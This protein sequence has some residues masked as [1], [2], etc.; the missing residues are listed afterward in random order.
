MIVWVVADA[1]VKGSETGSSFRQALFFKEIGFNLHD[2]MIWNK[3][4]SFIYDITRYYA[5]FEYMF[6]LSKG[7]PKAVNLIKDKPN[8]T[9]GKAVCY[10]KRQVDGT[11]SITHGHTHNK[12]VGEYGIRYNVWDIYPVQSNLERTGHPAQFPEQLARDHIITWSD[13]GDVV[14]DPFMGSGTTGKVAI[15]LN[16]NFIGAEI[17]SEYYNI[18]EARINQQ[19]TTSCTLTNSEV[20]NSQY[21]KL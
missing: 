20:N 18:A 11:T 13:E 17:V 1:V 5:S 2:T 8:K 4:T 21:I 10:S 3:H 19:N 15:E 12:V 14:F 9:P 6:I 16:R 7:K